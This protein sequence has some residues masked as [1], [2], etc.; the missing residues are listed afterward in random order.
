MDKRDSFIYRRKGM[1]MKTKNLSV[2]IVIPFVGS[3]VGFFHAITI[4]G[5]EIAGRLFARSF[6]TWPRERRRRVDNPRKGD[7]I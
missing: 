3:D 5:S 2:F 6:G 7:P 4:G 1:E